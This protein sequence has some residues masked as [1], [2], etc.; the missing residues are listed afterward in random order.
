MSPA[1]LLSFA[2]ADGFI[3][4]EGGGSNK[5]DSSGDD[6][7]KEATTAG[8]PNVHSKKLQKLAVPCCHGLLDIG[9]Q[10]LSNFKHVKR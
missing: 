1:F 4:G 6:L 8:S 10:A 9:R 7:V 3:T 2:C 5:W